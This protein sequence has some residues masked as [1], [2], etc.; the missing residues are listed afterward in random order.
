MALDK[1]EIEDIAFAVAE[2]LRERHMI[3][4]EFPS[5]VGA[6]IRELNHERAWA[7]T[8]VITMGSYNTPVFHV[9][10]LPSGAIDLEFRDVNGQ[11]F[12]RGRLVPVDRPHGEV[13]DGL[14]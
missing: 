8:F 3:P 2:E 9:V 7:T 5:S 14:D 4:A 6:W 13:P 12:W 11:M 1:Q 10:M